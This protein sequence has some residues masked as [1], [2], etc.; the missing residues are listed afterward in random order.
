MGAQT[1]STGPSWAILVADGS[2]ELEPAAPTGP[3]QHFKS[4]NAQLVMCDI[5]GLQIAHLSGHGL[6]Q[7]PLLTSPSAGGEMPKMLA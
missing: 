3:C 7:P 2:P 6:P 4:H 5:V 1:A